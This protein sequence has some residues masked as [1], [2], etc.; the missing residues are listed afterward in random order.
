[1]GGEK[2]KVVSLIVVDRSKYVD[3][4]EDKCM[5]AHFCLICRVCLHVLHSVCVFCI[6]RV[7]KTKKKTG[8]GV[9]SVQI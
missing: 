5:Y 8:I 1:M 2:T 4:S 9:W 7:V 6:A 3:G